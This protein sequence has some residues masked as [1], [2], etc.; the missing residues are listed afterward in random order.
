MGATILILQE[1]EGTTIMARHKDRE[2]KIGRYLTTNK[3]ATMRQL[4]DAL[5]EPINT[6]R[7]TIAQM[8]KEGKIEIGSGRNPFYSL[9]EI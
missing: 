2:I 6:V 1:M 5:G 4:S 8:I 9:R 7:Y 3:K